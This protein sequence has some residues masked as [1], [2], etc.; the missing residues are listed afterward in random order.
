[1]L[2]FAEDK[3]LKFVLLALLAALWM[4]LC[5]CT[6][7]NKQLVIAECKNYNA[8]GPRQKKYIA[9][10]PTLA[11]EDKEGYT[12]TIETW[13]E[14]LLEAAKEVKGVKYDPATDR[15]EFDK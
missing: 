13:Q 6:S 7:L 2:M 12:D 5:G 4:A 9:A 8:I 14:G 11:K 1:M 3:A 10:D 15:F